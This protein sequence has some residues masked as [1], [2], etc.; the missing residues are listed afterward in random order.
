MPSAFILPHSLVIFIP[1]AIAAFAALIIYRRR[2]PGK[3]DPHMK[4]IT[5]AAVVPYALM[6]L[7]SVDF[8]KAEL[9]SLPVWF[10]Y[11]TFAD[12]VYHL[13]LKLPEKWRKK[14]AMGVFAA[15]ALLF[16]AGVAERL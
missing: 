7:F 3:P 4:F 16:L 14:A 9:R 8:F 1:A 13:V 10:V 2:N 15:L 6:P 5:V 12:I 11:W